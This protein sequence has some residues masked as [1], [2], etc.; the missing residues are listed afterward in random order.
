MLLLGAIVLAA[1]GG[2]DGGG[3]DDGGGAAP[4]AR[5]A[6][7]FPVSVRADQGE[8]AIEARPERVVSLSPSLTEMLYAVGAGDQVVAVDRNSDFP[9]GVPV[10]D[11]S[12]LRP[13]V[14][15]MGGY[16][17]DL[18]VLA[19]DRD[20]IVGALTALG[21]PTLLLGSPAHL[22]DV[23]DQLASIGA[24]TGHAAEADEVVDE[25]RDELDELAGALPKR[26]RPLRYFFEVSD[27]YHSVTSQTFTGELLRL[28]GLAS[29]ADAAGGAAGGYPQLSAE[30]VLDA[31]PDLI[32][33]AHAGGANPT[34]DQVAARAG[35]NRLAA[36]SNGRVVALEPD[37]ASRWGP[38]IVDLLRAVVQAVEALPGA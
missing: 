25:I 34:S 20:G 29:I 18:V 8:V 11:L 10:T 35:W 7:D 31:D 16:R 14:E 38:R 6:A 4:E 21:V 27:T 33:L 24:A 23:Y 1:C 12:G 36:V 13:N 2:D 37:L 32:F 17:P 3:D 15:A 30:F 19:N 9:D 28:A 26:S 22:D 5:E